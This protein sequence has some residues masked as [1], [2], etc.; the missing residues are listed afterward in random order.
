MPGC[1]RGPYKG[2]VASSHTTVELTQV[3]ILGKTLAPK[4]KQFQLPTF[5]GDLGDKGQQRRSWRSGQ[6]QLTFGTSSKRS[7]SSLLYKA[8]MKEKQKQI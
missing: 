2:F 1:L 4:D 3:R 5:L 8:T 6:E 7:W